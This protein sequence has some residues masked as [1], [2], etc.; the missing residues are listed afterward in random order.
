MRAAFIASFIV[1][2]QTGHSLLERPGVLLSIAGEREKG[3]GS[4]APQGS[5]RTAMV[6]K[7]HFAVFGHGILEALG[8]T[9]GPGSLR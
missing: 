8:D 1:A 3:R 2:G 4:F 9:H 5:S 7:C 6:R